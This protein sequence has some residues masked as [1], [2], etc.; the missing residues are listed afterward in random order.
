MTDQQIDARI[1]RALRLL[2]DD[3][4]GGSSIIA[5]FRNAANRLDP[6]TSPPEIKAVPGERG[7]W[8]VVRG[9]QRYAENVDAFTDGPGTYYSELVANAIAAALR[10]REASK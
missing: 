6:T 1:A 5:A 3:Y 7:M 4:R 2:Y 10:E 8:F 9:H